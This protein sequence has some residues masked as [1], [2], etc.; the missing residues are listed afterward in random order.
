MY[1][2]KVLNNEVFERHFYDICI[3]FDIFYE[4]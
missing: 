3:V 4:N 1:S 2:G